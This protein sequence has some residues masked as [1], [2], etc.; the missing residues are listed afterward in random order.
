MPGLG[1][2]L[3]PEF[4][5]DGNLGTQPDPP[6]AERS[7]MV[8]PVLPSTAGGRPVAAPTSPPS[9]QVKAQEHSLFR[10][11]LH[12][13]SEP[14]NRIQCV[15]SKAE[16]APVAVEHSGPEIVPAAERSASLA[17]EPQPSLGPAGGELAEWL[18]LINPSGCAVEAPPAPAAC[19]PHAAVA[20]VAELVERW[21]RRV[22]LGGDQRRGAV[23]LDIGQGR[24][25]G[26]E[27]VIVAEGDRVSIDL[28]LP[29][30]LVDAELSARLRSRLE[31]RGYQ[32][33]VLVR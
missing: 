31:R 7:I 15:A 11:Q 1:P 6:L 17:P 30:A 32:A 10:A 3:L 12:R 9:R 13:S 2:S 26:A 8:Q 24:F 18:W 33:D 25:S 20:E 28:T 4:L 21:V 14:L 16:E 5:A 27:L 29:P 23:R 22:A 19:V